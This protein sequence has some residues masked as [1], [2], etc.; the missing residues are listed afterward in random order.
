MLIN[1]FRPGFF[2]FIFNQ[3]DDNPARVLL[4]LPNFPKKIKGL[5][6]KLLTELI[7]SCKGLFMLLFLVLSQ[8]QMSYISYFWLQRPPT[9]HTLR[10][11]TI[12]NTIDLTSNVYHM[13]IASFVLMYISRRLTYW[14]NCFYFIC[15]FILRRVVR[16]PSR[17]A[18]WIN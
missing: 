5:F 6:P 18:I 4:Y 17:D 10:P 8:T 16:D 15:F 14:N 7:L 1:R 3:I 11:Y 2:F 12:S 13:A 9:P